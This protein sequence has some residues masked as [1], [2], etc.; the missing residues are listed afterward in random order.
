MKRTPR[1]LSGH[2]KKEFEAKAYAVD[3]KDGWPQEWF[4]M[5]VTCG[6]P[7]GGRTKFW[8]NFGESEFCPACRKVLR[9]A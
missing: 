4:C 6:P 8:R 2:A 3:E 1:K 7:R 9:K 5:N